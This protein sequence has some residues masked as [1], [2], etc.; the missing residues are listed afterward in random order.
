MKKHREGGRELGKGKV[1][2]KDWR[3]RN[4]DGR[5]DRWQALRVRDRWPG[6]KGGKRG[7]RPPRALA[8]SL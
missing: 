3:G 5:K 1:H 6:G 7:L 4:F 2:R 8:E